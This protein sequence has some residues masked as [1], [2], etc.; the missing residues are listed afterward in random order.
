MPAT[1]TSAPATESLQ[2]RPALIHD[3]AERSLALQP[4]AD[5]RASMADAAGYSVMVGIGETYFVPFAL[6]VGAGKT[7]GGLAATLPMLAGATLQ[8]AS[9][10]LV[11]R[12][13]SH[14]LWV[15]ACV[16]LQALSVFMLPVAI[17]LAPDST[18]SNVGGFPASVWWIYCAATVYWFAG[19]SG[20]PSWNTWIETIIPKRIRTR[21]FSCRTRAGQAFTLLGF[22]SGGLALHWAKSNGLVLSAF[23]SILLVA[24]AARLFSGFAL[25][26]QSEPLRG[27][28]SD[29]HVPLRTIFASTAKNGGTLVWYLLAMQTA[30]QISGPYFNSYLIL[31]QRVSYFD[32]MLMIGLGFAGKVL[33]TPFWGRFAQRCGAKRLLWVGGIAIIPISSFWVI[34]DWFSVWQWTVPVTLP[35]S[36][37]HWVVTGEFVYLCV[38]QLIS[39]VTWAAYELAMLLMFFEAIPRQDRTGML[40]FYNW[41][42][43]IAMVLGSFLGAAVLT[44]MNES[45]GAFLTLFGLSSVARLLTVGLLYWAPDLRLH[46]VPIAPVPLPVGPAR[47]R[48]D[49]PVLVSL[50]EPKDKAKDTRDSGLHRVA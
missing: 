42:N 48:L 38:V 26:Q 30:V 4:R 18:N 22:A 20:G 46:S 36:D 8:L 35:G 25:L 5:I 1:L 19:L 29:R 50:P 6:A 47:I 23:C 14:R 27:R 28:I 16:F 2:I 41:G 24:A 37:G 34:S 32:Y 13:G 12:L 39:G 11:R 33:A 49:Q 15:A 17:L 21:F 44:S 43:S 9:P 3:S 31:D 7:A 40:T 10:W 45:H